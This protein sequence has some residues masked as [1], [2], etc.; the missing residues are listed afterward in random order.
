MAKP[1]IIWKK[2]VTVKNAFILHMLDQCS[3][4]PSY[5]AI[6]NLPHYTGVSW[7]ILQII[8]EENLKWNYLDWGDEQC[9]GAKISIYTL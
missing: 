5:V 3:T 2:S 4:Y 8:S 9:T 7:A 6:I 1:H